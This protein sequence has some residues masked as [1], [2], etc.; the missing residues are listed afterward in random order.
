MPIF[1]SASETTLGFQAMHRILGAYPGL[2]NI[3]NFITFFITFVF[4][5]PTPQKKV[6]QEALRVKV[7]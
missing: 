3:P 6:Y 4:H 7:L 1:S 5:A 2:M